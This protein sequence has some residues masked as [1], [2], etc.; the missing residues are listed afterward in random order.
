MTERP[1]I[2]GDRLLGRLQELAV[3]SAGGPGVTR[4]AY[5]KE[6]IAA[7]H[8]V[9]RWMEQAGLTVDVDSAANLIGR[10]AGA[11]AGDP[12]IMLGSH[13]DTVPEGGRFDGVYGVLAAIEAADHLCRGSSVPSLAVVAFANEEGVVAPPGRS[14]SRAVAGA[15]PSPSLVIDSTG[16]TLGDLIAEGNHS[17]GVRWRAA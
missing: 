12:A 6:D 2:N 16:Q 10:T 5:S 9:G 11:A 14:G 3:I 4:I 13:L 1:T 8:L 15:P 7:R 17:G